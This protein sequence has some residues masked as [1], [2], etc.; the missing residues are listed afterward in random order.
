MCEEGVEDE[1]EELAGEALPEVGVETPES[2]FQIMAL[3]FEFL[4]MSKSPLTKNGAPTFRVG[5][6]WMLK[7][8]EF[9]DWPKLRG[10]R[11]EDVSLTD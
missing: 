4:D 5:P 1:V 7:L 8:E 3:R 10:T 11:R 6:C 2:R 9:Q